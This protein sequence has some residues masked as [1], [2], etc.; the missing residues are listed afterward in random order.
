MSDLDSDFETQLLELA[1]AS[2]R[3]SKKSKSK[4]DRK[5]KSD[6]DKDIESEED[7]EDEE[8]SDPYPYEGQYVDEED[9]QKLLSLPEIKR[10]G[11]LAERNEEKQRLQEKQVLAQMV[12]QQRSGGGGADDD[13]VA[14][15]A[16]RTHMARGQAN[17]K[18]RKLDELKAIRK[19]KVESRK[20]IKLSPTA[21]RRS[22]SPQDMDIS[23]EDSEDGQFTKSD[24]EDE[25]ERRLMGNHTKA[26][27]K[28]PA[29]L[30]DFN[31][32]RLSRDMVAKWCLT[33]WFPNYVK[34]A[35]VRYLIGKDKDT[36]EDVYRIC[37]VQ[38]L[39]PNPVKPYNVNDRMINLAVNLKHGKA[40]K[41]FNMDRI[42]NSDIS[43]REYD[44]LQR[45]YKTE[46]LE[47]PTR[48]A[49]KHKAAEMQK[50]KSQP[51]TDSDIS[52]MVK[53][54]KELSA[55]KSKS[56][57]VLERSR[58][59]QARS[60]ALKRLDEKE[61]EELQDQIADLD[62]QLALTASNSPKKTGLDDKDEV[63]RRVNERNRKANQDAVRRA[64]IADNGRR[65]KERAKAANGGEDADM[66]KYDPSARLKT[67]PRIFNAATPSTRP[68]TPASKTGTP[69]PPTGPQP[70]ANKDATIRPLPSS[71]T[72]MAFEKKLLETMELDLGDF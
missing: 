59:T 72:T 53:R 16:K 55:T 12:R 42:S 13:T 6:S 44:R 38:E 11:I 22:S 57:L 20:R 51:L 14:R 10:E 9:K 64:E 3:K 34:N 66:T 63:L 7:L 21:N 56:E 8:M 69:A 29:T 60:L 45:T 2:D 70:L 40:L 48:K 28:L 25:R 71:N 31:R 4:S 5:R 65:K 67:N 46:K 36:G 54:K 24:Q 52:L 23:D 58:L 61:A 47:F 68:G 39:S 62:S 18:S 41:Q 33:P 1:G 49:L 35:W 37:E 43:Q 19:A 26:E 17:P 15:A 32:C 30:E 50:L 27:D